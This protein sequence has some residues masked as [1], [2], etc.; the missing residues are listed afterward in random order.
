MELQFSSMNLV[1][2]S[3]LI[4]SCWSVNVAVRERNAANASSCNEIITT[5]TLD[6][7][8]RTGTEPIAMTFVISEGWHC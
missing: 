5:E 4:H 7:Q 8:E 2:H 6:L 1:F 3:L